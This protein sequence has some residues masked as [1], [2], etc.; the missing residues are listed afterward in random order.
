MSENMS[1]SSAQGHDR[2]VSKSKHSR[3]KLEKGSRTFCILG[4]ESLPPAH[5]A[6][7][8]SVVIPSVSLYVH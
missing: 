3:K 2:K 8:Q 4:N 5:Q 1:L 7:N 6:F